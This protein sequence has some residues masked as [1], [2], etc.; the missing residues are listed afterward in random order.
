MNIRNARVR[1]RGGRLSAP[2]GR[3]AGWPRA[4]APEG[5]GPV[6]LRAG[7]RGTCKAEAACP[8]DLVRGAG[9]ADLSFA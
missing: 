9:T 3:R 6:A 2:R 4:H 8:G 7:G 1:D 5:P